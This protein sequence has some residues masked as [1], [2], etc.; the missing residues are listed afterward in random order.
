MFARFVH[1]VICI[2]N[3]FLFAAEQYSTSR[4]LC[5]YTTSCLF[6]Y[7]LV[8]TWVVSA[9][10]LLWIMLQVSVS[11][12]NFDFGALYLGVELLNCT[13]IQS[14]AFERTVELVSTE[15]A[16]FYIPMSNIRGFQ[17]LY[18]F[19]NTCYF[20]FLFFFLI[21]AILVCVRC[22]LVVALIFNS[23]VTCGIEHLFMRLLAIC[24]FSLE[25]Y[26]FM[27]F[28]HFKIGL[29]GFCGWFEGVFYMFWILNPYQIYDLQNFPFLSCPFALLRMH[30]A[31]QKF[32]GLMNPI[33][34]FIFC[35]FSVSCLRIQ[36]HTE[37]RIMETYSYVF[38]YFP[39]L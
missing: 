27:P 31:A 13:L 15:A 14:L 17:L 21:I 16:A 26:L 35:C 3:L 23:L 22:Y 34:L 12:S 39:S 38:F 32:L 2:S 11:V 25:N 1:I 33:Y 24:I 4:V 9:L 30:F 19:V 36:D 6:T 20:P 10:C 18:I 5:A 29:F 28:A 7:L 37:S 8:D